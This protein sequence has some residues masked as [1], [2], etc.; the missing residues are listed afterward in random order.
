[1]SSNLAKG[2]FLIFI[3]NI[4]FRVGGYVYRV[5]MAS[6]LGPASYGILTITLQFQG[7]FQVLS[8]AGLPPA[9]AKYISQYSA[10]D[11]EALA[12]QTI[13]T[14]LK[15]M[16]CLGIFFGLAMFFFVAPW[17]ALNLFKKPETLIP[18][19]YVGFITPFSVIVGAFRGSFQGVYKMEYILATRTVE[20]IFMIIFATLLVLL[21]FSVAGAVL[22]SVLGFAASAALSVFIFL[23]YMGKYIP[24]PKKEDKFP[25]KEELKLAKK[26]VF[27]AIPV[28]VTALAEMGI[29]SICSFVMGIFLAS[30]L[31]G[32]FGAADPIA[33]LPLVI[34]ISVAT[35]ILPASSAAFSMKNQSLLNKYVNSAFKYGMI[36]VIPMCIGI[37]ML[38][39]PIMSLVYF[40]KPEFVLGSTALSILVVG[41]TFYSMFAISSSIVQG[42]GNPRIPMYILILGAAIALGL[43]WIMVPLFGI[44]GGAFATSIA[45]FIMM[46]PMLY[47]TFKLTKVKVPY[48]TFGKI[49]LASLIMGMII[50]FIPKNSY[51]LILSIILCPTIYLLGLTLLKTF[52]EN[53]I[54]TIRRFSK[55]FKP[56]YKVIDK[57]LKFI[58]RFID[59]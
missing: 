9:I 40:A 8:A 27:F 11:E 1:M 10:L 4:V 7:I 44:E 3:G 49:I 41:M 51:G 25:M 2:S 29:Y 17:I 16:I 43:N 28:T 20:Q 5:L 38:S 57:I 23:K 24:Q 36:F 39:E 14:S 59:K 18:L 31:I 52:D 48:G 58:E 46:V 35:T 15:I 50:H 22:G 12:R 53:D 19:Q 54:S 34:S 33:R 32:Y 6:L 21:G 47:L 42:I 37:A 13:Y 56:L 45:C 26:L 30:N 55:K